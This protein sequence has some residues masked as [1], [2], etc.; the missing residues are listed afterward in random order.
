M[1]NWRVPA[2]ELQAKLDWVVGEIASKSG[3]VIKLTKRA[4]AAGRERAFGP[5]LDEAERIYL[6]ELCS[7]EDIGEGIAAYLGKRQPEWRHR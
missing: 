6:E 4:I 7:T 3:A 5:A 1:V 2:A